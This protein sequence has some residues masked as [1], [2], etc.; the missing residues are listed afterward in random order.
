M[1]HNAIIIGADHH[2]TLGVVRSLG[3]K[4]INSDV[5]IIPYRNKIRKVKSK[6]IN[7]IKSFP[8]DRQIISELLGMESC[9]K[10]VLLATCDIA[11]SLL[12]TNYDL[13]KDK[14]VLF[15]SKGH[16]TDLMSKE[17]MCHLAMEVGLNIP[18]YTIWSKGTD[19]PKNIEFPVITKAISSIDGNKSDTAVCQSDEELRN[20]L[21]NPD[22]CP[23]IQIEK[24]IQKEFEFQFIGVS[25]DGGET[26][27]IPGH[28]H[29][30]RPN[31]VQNTYYF[32]YKE[33][34]K[35]FLTT[36]KLTKDFIR[37]SGYSGLFSVEFLRDKDG[38][39]YF[40]EMNFRN[41]GNAICVTDAGYNLPYI[42]YLYA[43][44]G[45]Y[46]TEI[47]NSK[48]RSVVFCPEFFYFKDYVYGEISFMTW[49]KD[50]IRANSYT[51]YWKGDNHLYWI[52]LLYFIMSQMRIK[53][54]VI[55][56]K[57]KAPKSGIG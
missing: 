18:E 46:K 30:V 38:K 54:Q 29:I 40:L 4:G 47:A 26:I 1:R 32:Q 9:V 39:D 55:R 53:I 36:L 23:H 19:M 6:Y 42:W 27:V 3:S 52:R 44:G 5:I 12:D 21:K 25:L 43:T 17:T 8:D 13:L 51:D 45:N 7:S 28:S 50:T 20:F 31:G 49:L 33:N 16:L 2:N 34:D 48:F 57:V 24:F 56:G 15:N 37:K 10:Q 22:L 35:S 14:F 41:D 11:S